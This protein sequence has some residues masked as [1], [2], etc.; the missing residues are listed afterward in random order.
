MPLRTV[1]TWGERLDS[2]LRRQLEDNLSAEL[3]TCY[4]ANEAVPIAWEC[5]SHK[6]LHV[7]GDHVVLECIPN[8]RIEKENTAGSA[9][10]TSLDSFAMP[11]IRY[12]LG[13]MLTP[14]SGTCPCGSALPLMDQPLGRDSE[15]V[16]L[17][18]GKTLSAHRFHEIGR[19]FRGIF[20]WQVIQETTRHFIVKLVINGQTDE[21]MDSHIQ[22]LFR[23]YLREPVRVDIQI[24][25]S[26]EADA[27]KTRTFI[28]K[29]PPLS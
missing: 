10:V 4:G 16:T 13:D 5:P 24:V 2:L 19:I 23:E 28:S 20:Q 11:F 29:V 17:S 14:Y 9:V 7:N 3:F 12:K 18:S 15:M 25:D 26:I 8:E 6:G 27:P 22:T 21:D 1:I